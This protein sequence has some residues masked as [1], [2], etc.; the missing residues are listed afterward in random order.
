M[1]KPPYLLALGGALALAGAVLLPRESSG[2][3]AAADDPAL[4]KLLGEL[5]AQ[6]IVIAENHGKIDEKLALIAEDVRIARIF[7]GRGGGKAK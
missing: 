7:V 1:N 3:A 6:Q 5:V 4:T 2:Q